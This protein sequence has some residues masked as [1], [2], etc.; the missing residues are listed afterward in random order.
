VEL[1]GLCLTLNTGLPAVA[2]HPHGVLGA[3][4]YSSFQLTEVVTGHVYTH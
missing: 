2:E 1:T 3:V 4:A